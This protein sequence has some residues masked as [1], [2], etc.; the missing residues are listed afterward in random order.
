[1]LKSFVTISNILIHN[2]WPANI[3]YSL[4]IM[5]YFNNE[6]RSALVDIGTKQNKGIKY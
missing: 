2:Q 6:N 3:S 4:R 1:M 5:T